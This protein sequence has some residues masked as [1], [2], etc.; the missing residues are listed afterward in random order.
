M[1]EFTYTTVPAKL[2][3]FI[4]RIPD[5][6][7]PG[8]VTQQEL[9]SRGFKSTND[10]TIIPVLKFIGLVGAEGT[11]TENWQAYRNK[12]TNKALIAELIRRAYSDLYQTYPDA[13]LRSDADIRNFIGG[14][15]KAGER[16]LQYMVTTF[17][18]LAQ[19]GDFGAEP[20]E[21]A[22]DE[23]VGKVGSTSLKV[24]Q[25]RTQTA[26]VHINLQIHLPDTDDGDRIDRI[27]KS[28]ATYIFDRK[29][30]E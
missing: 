6:G 30:E 9:S 8:K 25:P 13:H 15:S 20:P 26:Q 23:V 14:K 7:V 21:V 1:A 16:A 24:A 28:M 17:K 12:G 4:D 27:F 29:L 3:S 18:T 22:A 11:P 10:R 19:M 5:T 2:K